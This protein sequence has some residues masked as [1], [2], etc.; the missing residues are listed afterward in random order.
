M[1]TRVHTHTHT[2]RVEEQLRQELNSTS[3]ELIDHER[4]EGTLKLQVQTIRADF[5]QQML[6]AKRLHFKEKEALSDEVLSLVL[7]H[8]VL[9]CC[10][11][12]CPYASCHVYIRISIH[13]N[14]YVSSHDL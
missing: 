5:E 14:S 2:H 1:Y 6:E 4:S 12:M 3:T 13:V 7:L 11:Y 10:P 8:V 9:V